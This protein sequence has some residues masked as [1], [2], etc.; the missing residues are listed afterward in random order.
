MISAKERKL[1]LGFASI[2]LTLFV[3]AVALEIYFYSSIPEP[4]P[5]GI[6]FAVHV[7]RTSLAGFH[8]MTPI[9]FLSLVFA[10]KY[11][12]STIL[13]SLYGIVF[14]ASYFVR[15]NGEGALGGEGFYDGRKLLE[16][17]NKSH[18]F[19]FAACVFVV[20]LLIWQISILNRNSGRISV[21]RSE[22]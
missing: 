19:D 21:Q 10:R 12:F 1:L 20:T 3:G 11:I 7:F 6:R 18:F 4:E 17:Y 2:F 22:T 13:T 5:G 16:I 9:I 14:I 8:L 15:L